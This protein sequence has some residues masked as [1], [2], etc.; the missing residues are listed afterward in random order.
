MKLVPTCFALS[1][2]TYHRRSISIGSGQPGVRKL[3][4]IGASLLLGSHCGSSEDVDFKILLQFNSLNGNRNRN[5]IL[6]FY[7]MQ[8][9]H[10]PTHSFHTG[11]VNL[12]EMPWTDLRTQQLLQAIQRAS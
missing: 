4:V 10:G 2:Q 5:L 1:L 9:F 11:N 12:G 3:L 6:H 7:W 8:K